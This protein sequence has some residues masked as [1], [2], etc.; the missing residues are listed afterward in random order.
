MPSTNKTPGLGLNSW[1]DTDKPRREDFV[2]DNRILDT[3]IENHV[4][5]TILHLTQADR[6]RLEDGIVCYSRD[7]SGA[8]EDFI[9]LDFEPQVVVAFL[10]EKPFTEH[11]FPE[12]YLVVNSGIATRVG[13]TAGIRLSGNK[14]Y[15]RQS[16]VA[17]AAGGLYLN[18]NKS[19]S[20]YTYFALR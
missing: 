3:V 5:D 4:K 8:E 18:L 15:F 10:Q 14:I 20:Q 2:E 16:Q 13:S 1:V 12:N 9:T 11:S 7:G 17:P 19:Y 6:I